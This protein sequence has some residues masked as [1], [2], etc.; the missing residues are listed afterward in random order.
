MSLFGVACALTLYISTM[1]ISKEEEE[2]LE[3]VGGNE[4]T[5][6]KEEKYKGSAIS[7]YSAARRSPTA[8]KKLD[9]TVTTLANK[10]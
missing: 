9:I 7:L 8:R 1:F 10:L 2:E 5:I 6:Q 3:R 4:R